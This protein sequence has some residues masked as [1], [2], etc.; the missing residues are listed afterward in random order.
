VY[1]VERGVVSDIVI[2]AAGLIVALIMN[3]RASAMKG[4]VRPVFSFFAPW[5]TDV[6]V[7][8]T[9]LRMR[10]ERVA[11]MVWYIT[12]KEVLSNSAS[13]YM[14]GFR[15]HVVLKSSHISQR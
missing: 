15:P 12:W 8:A 6:C 13:V 5:L 11:A 2:S 3:N 1:S 4:V 9:N 10:R 14:T 7:S